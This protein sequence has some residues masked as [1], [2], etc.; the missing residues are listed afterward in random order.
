MIL[1]HRLVRCYVTERHLRALAID[2]IA[3]LNAEP[4]VRIYADL[5]L[6]GVVA[7]MIAVTE[8]LGDV[9]VAVSDRRHFHAVREV[10]GFAWLVAAV[11]K[12][13]TK[14]LYAS[15]GTLRSNEFRLTG[16]AQGWAEQL[17]LPRSDRFS[18]NPS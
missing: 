6:G 12:P 3:Q 9:D 2:Q 8:R 4:L 16:R 13:V 7:S 1:T 15:P 5:P 10:R 18:G 14:A 11:S 17:R